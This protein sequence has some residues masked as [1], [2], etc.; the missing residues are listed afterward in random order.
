[1]RNQRKNRSI[2]LILTS[3][4]LI[5]G[6]A[7]KPPAFQEG[8]DAEVTFDG[9]VRLDHTAFQRVWA[10]PEADVSGYTKVLPMRA[11]IEFRAV[12]PVGSTQRASSS[13]TEFPIDEKTQQKIVDIVSEIFIEEIGKNTR[14]AITDKPGPDTLILAGSLLDIVSFI[15]P[16]PIGRSD[17]FVS[18]VGEIT[19][20]IE[21][22]DS[23]SGETLLRAAERGAAARPG[24]TGM[25][26]N[27]AT[28]QQEVRRLARR[29]GT[30]LRE[31][32]DGL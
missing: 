21:L 1:M 26:S 32:L 10:D 16:E 27:S 17:I 9:L 31:G 15:P 4:V 3:A 29:W 22:K 25:R 20:V 13:T 18:S 23:L 5:A 8:P 2:S 12:K 14:F 28:N 6:C 19:L 7:S 24:N 11:T 30:R